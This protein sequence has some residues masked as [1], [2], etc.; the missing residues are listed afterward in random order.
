MVFQKE[1]LAEI[2]RSILSCVRRESD[3]VSV[4]QIISGAV[5]EFFWLVGEVIR[6]FR[7]RVRAQTEVY[8]QK[9]LINSQE[10]SRHLKA[11][12]PKP[13]WQDEPRGAR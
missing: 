6:R 5:R 9:G 11:V 4:L 12:S 2:W 1:Y 3:G 7:L 10:A 13:D 8:I